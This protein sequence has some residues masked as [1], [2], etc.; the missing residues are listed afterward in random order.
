[1]YKNVVDIAIKNN[2]WALLHVEFLLL[3]LIDYEEFCM[4]ATRKDGRIFYCIQGSLPHKSYGTIFVLSCNSCIDMIERGVIDRD[5]I[6][7]S[8]GEYIQDY[9]MGNDA[10]VAY[11][12]LC[13]I[14]VRN[15]RESINSIN[16]HIFK[17]FEYRAFN[18][19]S[20]RNRIIDIFS[21][22]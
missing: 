1:M 14:A 7:Y 16:P 5:H 4:R 18:S 6:L 21:C 12:K 8:F 11:K 10:V 20:F 15:R 13:T 17:P 9:N 3:D 2:P 19:K 22:V